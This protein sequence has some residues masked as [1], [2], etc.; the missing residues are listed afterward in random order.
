MKHR[1][2]G[3]TLVEI[4][5]VLVIIGLLLGGILKGQEMINSAKVRNIAD[6]GNAVKAAFFAF[7][8]RYRAVPGDYAAALTNVKGTSIANGNGNGTIDS[9]VERGQV[10]LQLASSGFISGTYDGAAV[11]ANWTCSATTCPTNTYGGTLMLSFG[12]EASGTTASANE[13]RTG[14]LIPVSV[15]AEVDRKVDDSN[16]ATGS[17]QSGGSLNAATCVVG[18]AYAVTAA[19]PQTNCG[20]VYLF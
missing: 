12:S 17:F 1:Q 9:N 15:V 10:W 11:A 18:G 4:A 16:P 3:F 2:S 13:L 20:G 6:Q 8:D 14:S 19:N 5:I 7:Q